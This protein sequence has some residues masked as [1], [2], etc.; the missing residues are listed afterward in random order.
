[1][2]STA[3]HVQKQTQFNDMKHTAKHRIIHTSSAESV[4]KKPVRVLTG[5]DLLTR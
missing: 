3:Q 2:T 4:L 1:M 5:Q